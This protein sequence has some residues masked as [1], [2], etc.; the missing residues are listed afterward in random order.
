[1]SIPKTD[2]ERVFPFFL[3]GDPD[4]HPVSPDWPADWTPLSLYE[5]L[6]KAWCA[7]TCAPRLRGEWSEENPTVGQCSVTAFLAQDIFGGD[8]FGIPLPG[9]GTHCYNRVGETV[10]DLTDAQ[11]LPEK[12]EYP[13]LHTQIRDVHFANEEKK[14]RYELLSARLKKAAAVQ[15]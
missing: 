3:T 5:A 4:V 2:N 9:G 7:E 14:K 11:F 1:M 13:C 12:L 10:F 15:K 6:K 8:V